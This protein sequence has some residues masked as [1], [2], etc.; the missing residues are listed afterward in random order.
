[1]NRRLFSFLGGEA[2]AWHVTG[3][4][5]IVG[6]PL[7]LVKCIDVVNGAVDSSPQNNQ[8]LLRGITSNERYVIQEEK[9]L[10][11]AKQEGSDR[12]GATMAALIPIRKNASWW[13]LAQDER[14]EILERRSQHIKTGLKYLPAIARRLHHCRDL[15]DNEPF[16]FLTW[17][18]YAP[19]DAAAFDELT[20]E[21]RESYEWSYI[22]REID[23]RLSREP[24]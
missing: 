16:D 10:L 23:I 24:G 21:L 13:S 4:K 5:T 8:W 22:D 12:P 18:E 20:A 1:M 3:M 14:R 6:D 11:V 9:Q 17:F 15:S 7:A 19:V 2:G